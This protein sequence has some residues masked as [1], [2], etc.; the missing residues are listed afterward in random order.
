MLL[1]AGYK[2]MNY[3]IYVN[4]MKNKLFKWGNKIIGKSSYSSIKKQKVQEK[5]K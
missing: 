3:F 2:I 5:Y 1:A 4:Y